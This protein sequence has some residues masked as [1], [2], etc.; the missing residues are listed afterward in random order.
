[1]E[2]SGMINTEAMRVR[3]HCS[4]VVGKD[5]F[6][7]LP[8]KVFVIGIDWFIANPESLIAILDM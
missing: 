8:F 6:C 2:L 7:A 4:L 3:V 5:F 1:M